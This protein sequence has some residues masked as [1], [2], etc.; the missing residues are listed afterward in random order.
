MIRKQAKCTFALREQLYTELFTF[1]GSV[2]KISLLQYSCYIY[3]THIFSSPSS[4]SETN[5]IANE[6]IILLSSSHMTYDC[7]T[8]Q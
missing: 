4:D 1:R 3:F 2:L 5:E 6:S 8:K 7:F